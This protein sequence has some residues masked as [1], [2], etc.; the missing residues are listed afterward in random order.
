MINRYRTQKWILGLA[1]I[2]LLGCGSDMRS[3]NQGAELAFSESTEL[4]KLSWDHTTDADGKVEL[5]YDLKIPYGRVYSV[6][7][8]SLTY[9]L[10]QLQTPGQAY[11]SY[12][13]PVGRIVD[14]SWKEMYVYN[15]E[16][17]EGVQSGYTITVDAF[18]VPVWLSRQTRQGIYTEDNLDAKSVIQKT[19]SAKWGDDISLR[20]TPLN[21]SAKLE[22]C[23]N[24]P[25][26]ALTVPQRSIHARA[27]K[28]TWYGQFSVSSDFTVNAGRIDWDFGRGCFMAYHMSL[29]DGQDLLQ[30]SATQ[31]PYLSNVKYAGLTV[32]IEN[33]L[34]RLVDNIMGW[35]NASFRKS[36]IKKV[37][38]SVNNIA[39]Q[40][41]ESGKWFS[42]MYS[43]QVLNSYGQKLQA[44]LHK[45][46]RR[47]GAF[48][49]SEDLHK[50]I[51]DNCR[52]LKFTHSEVWTAKHQKFC[53]ELAE[54]IELSIDP[55]AADPDSQ[56]L[57]CYA[58]FA[59]VR[60]QGQ[61]WAK[62]CHFDVRF[63]IKVSVGVKDY[64]D[65]IHDILKAQ[66][67]KTRIPEEWKALLKE[68]KVDEYLLNLA[69]EEAEK[70]GYKDMDINT[71]RAQLPTWI[72]AVKTRL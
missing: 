28:K 38:N 58:R 17:Y 61:W 31:A 53:D 48:L 4:G 30:I 20:W 19:S 47:I 51:Q 23:M 18:Q 68:K 15:V 64:L 12:E 27:R 52:L 35:F 11:N 7:S 71:L 59:N 22:M 56:A 44:S 21:G 45:S 50:L 3:S 63:S 9:L 37:T 29:P 34:L 14:N 6:L 26:G 10:P 13:V 72:E 54:S 8:N 49:N 57:G 32:R 70:R 55:M 43:D 5:S 67:A 40:D 24:I 69:L 66:I 39:D 41:I 36:L 1:L 62:Q 42:K 16:N 65:E 2:A 46:T 60:S 33:W 25:G